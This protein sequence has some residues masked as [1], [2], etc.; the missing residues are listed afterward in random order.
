VQQSYP[1]DPLEVYCDPGKM[2]I[3]QGPEG[4]CKSPTKY[5]Q[6]VFIECSL[7]LIG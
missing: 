1:V 5:S 2:H 6:I 7:F 3:F 4:A